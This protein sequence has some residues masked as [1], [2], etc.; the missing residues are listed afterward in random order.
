MIDGLERIA[1]RIARTGAI[2][3]FVA[4]V[5]L[6]LAMT[7]NIGLRWLFAAPVHGVDDLARLVTAIAVA[8]ALPVCLIE[9]GNISVDALGLALSRVAGPW[10][11]RLLEAFGAL[12]TLALVAAM[13]RQLA[14]FA[15]ENTRAGATTLVLGWPTGPFWH[16]VTV[17]FALAVLAQ[18]V[19][20][21]ALVGRGFSRRQADG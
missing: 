4:L 5:L 11:H 7:G 8:S 3:G 1:R 17:F 19:V 9:R 14:L 18:A 13:C 10:G 21:I 6:A 16:V 20:V 2:L 15:A 12:L